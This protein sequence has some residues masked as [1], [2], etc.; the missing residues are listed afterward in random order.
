MP[1]LLVSNIQNL[2]NAKFYSHQ[3]KLVYRILTG[4]IFIPGPN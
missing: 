3:N 1:K 2:E 4:N